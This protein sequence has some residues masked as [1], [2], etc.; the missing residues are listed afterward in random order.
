MIPL[1]FFFFFNSGKKEILEQG[2]VQIIGDPSI[3]D[4]HHRHFLRRYESK[5]KEFPHFNLASI[6]VATNNFCDLNKLGQGGF[7][8]FYKVIP[9]LIN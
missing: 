3:L 9:F 8:P 2:M 5:S 6:Q 7:G 1:F 4:F